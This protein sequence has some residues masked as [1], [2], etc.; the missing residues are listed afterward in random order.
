MGR[1]KV[2]RKKKVKELAREHA[3]LV[4]CNSSQEVNFADPISMIDDE[5]LKSKVAEE[6]GLHMPPMQPRLLFPGIVVAWHGPRQKGLS[7]P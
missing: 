6:A 5:S 3:A 2:H 7:E 1:A 4:P